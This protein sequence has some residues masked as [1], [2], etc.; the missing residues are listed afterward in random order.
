M[1]SLFAG[2]GITIADNLKKL[3]HLI[4][5]MLNLTTPPTI[6]KMSVAVAVIKG[7]IF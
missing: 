5:V 1:N 2:P 3:V 4:T 7:W 6:S